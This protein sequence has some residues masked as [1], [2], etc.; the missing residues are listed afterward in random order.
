M[1]VAGKT[2]GRGVIIE[3]IVEN[4]KKLITIIAKAA[5]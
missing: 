1:F 2:S 3:F 5:K 4:G